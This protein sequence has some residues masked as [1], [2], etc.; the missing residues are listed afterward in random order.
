MSW[1]YALIGLALGGLA[2]YLLARRFGDS[3]QRAAE[4]Q[5]ELDR[6][7]EEHA[8][9]R[10]DVSDHFAKTAV[11]VN[12]LTESYRDVH[13]QLSEGARALCDNAAAETALAFDQSRLIDAPVAEPH[14]T[15]DGDAPETSLEQPS[16]EPMETAVPAQAEEDTGPAR[17]EHGPEHAAPAADAEPESARPQAEE[18]DAAPA[19]GGA[20]WTPVTSPEPPETPEAVSPPRDYAEDEG[21]AAHPPPR[22]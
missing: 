4:L 17:D 5:K 8:S 11:A 7:R 22:G 9:Y 13:Q 3:A 14:G 12:Q 18:Q 19:Q 21:D 1:F 20:S 15:A 2:G 16:P 10:R 6:A